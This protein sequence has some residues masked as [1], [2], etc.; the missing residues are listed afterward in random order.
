MFVFVVIIEL[1]IAYC[2][3]YSIPGV[4]TLF[5]FWKSYFWA[6]NEKVPYTRF[7]GLAFISK[8]TRETFLMTIKMSE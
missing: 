7:V 8:L 5:V 4:D 6:P 3:E 1:H 2:K